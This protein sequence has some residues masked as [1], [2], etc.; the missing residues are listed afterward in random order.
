MN[1]EELI[2]KK[3]AELSEIIRE[4]QL[5]V[6]KLQADVQMVQLENRILKSQ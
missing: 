5:L 2:A 3:A 1:N 4:L 6:A